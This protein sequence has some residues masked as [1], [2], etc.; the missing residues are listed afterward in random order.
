MADLFDTRSIRDDPRHW[1]ALAQR[2]ATRARRESAP[3]GVEWLARSRIGW[4][5]ASLLLAAA[6]AIERVWLA[7]PSRAAVGAA[8]IESLGPGDELGK[9]MTSLQRSPTLATLLLGAQ[10]E[11]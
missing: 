4:V 11:R 6:V 10:I 8:W 1:D 2:I 3:N 7:T 9:A 5:A